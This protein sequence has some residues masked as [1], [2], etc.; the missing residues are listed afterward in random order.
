MGEHALE[1][2]R[3]G[4]LLSD[5]GSR[6]SLRIS[7]MKRIRRLSKNANT[8]AKR[9]GY[10]F[11]SRLVISAGTAGGA[12]LGSYFGKKFGEK[13]TK[14]FLDSSFDFLPFPMKGSASTFIA[15]RWGP[16]I[17]RHFGMFAGAAAGGALSKK[18]LQR[19]SR[20]SARL[21]N[22]APRKLSHATSI[23]YSTVSSTS[24]RI[25]AALGEK[26]L[27]FAVKRTPASSAEPPVRRSS[28]PAINLRMGLLRSSG[29]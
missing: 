20:A 10:R 19:T 6:D 9:G 24:S 15:K 16:E 28:L 11:A 2:E 27:K 21:S 22:D 8:A 4:L 29:R 25:S 3:L 13:M 5:E 12:A 26:F 17:G 1:G 7:M 14:R 18:F 23:V